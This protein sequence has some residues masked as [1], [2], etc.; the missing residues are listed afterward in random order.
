MCLTE[1]TF[2][3]WIK[4]QVELRPDAYQITAM[5]YLPYLNYGPRPARLHREVTQVLQDYAGSPLVNFVWPATL[6]KEKPFVSCLAARA[7]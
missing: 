5:W 2:Q 6:D 4:V 1:L 3:R 7:S